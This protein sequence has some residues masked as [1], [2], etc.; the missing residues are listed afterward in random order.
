LPQNSGILW[1]VQD[2]VEALFKPIRE[3]SRAANAPLLEKLGFSTTELELL[4]SSVPARPDLASPE[5]KRAV[6]TSALRGA[7]RF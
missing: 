4:A 7:T 3:R 2:W 5:L 6:I 1:G